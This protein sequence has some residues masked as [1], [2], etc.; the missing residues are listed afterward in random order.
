MTE[1]E[2][3]L[4]IDTNLFIR[5]AAR[6]MLGACCERTRTRLY[7]P[8]QTLRE[9]PEKI[10]TLY[11]RA[12][13]RMSARTRPGE[14]ESA[15]KQRTLATLEA[16]CA[17]FVKWMHEEGKRNDGIYQYGRARSMDPEV[18]SLA[19]WIGTS[20]AVDDRSDALI[21]AECLQRRT[22]CLSSDNRKT[23]RRTDF[24]DWLLR[25]RE[26]GDPW[27]QVEVPFVLSADEAVQRLLGNGIEGIGAIVGAA[28]AV[29]RTKAGRT[30]VERVASLAWFAND[31]EKASLEGTAS[32]I[33][34]TLQD[35]E[36]RERQL[37]ERLE[38]VQPDV[39]KTREA[40]DRRLF[41]ERRETGTG[42]VMRGASGRG[43]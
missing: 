6:R 30:P 8:G 11:G 40:E 32:R 25:R 9:A 42:G 4:G 16:M 13:A 38:S 31:L 20:G 37:V 23:I 14:T 12:A 1:M 17:G 34:F 26:D 18:R 39:A 15:R 35:W 33:R 43:P 19:D 28:Y 27:A 10:R 22:I 21:I 7:V 3:A 24:H 36:G 41:L 2:T 5:Q 29:C